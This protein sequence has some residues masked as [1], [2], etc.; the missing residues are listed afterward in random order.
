VNLGRPKEKIL[1]ISKSKGWFLLGLDFKVGKQLGNTL[2]SEIIESLS[3][4]KIFEK[5]GRNWGCSW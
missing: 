2:G 4:K 1:K 3:H 5:N